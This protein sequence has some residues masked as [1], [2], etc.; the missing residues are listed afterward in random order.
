[1]S[2]GGLSLVLLPWKDK[3][4]GFVLRRRDPQSHRPRAVQNEEQKLRGRGNEGR[5][6]TGDSRLGGKMVLVAKGR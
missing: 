4:P 3:E 5:G 6:A 2:N 1:M